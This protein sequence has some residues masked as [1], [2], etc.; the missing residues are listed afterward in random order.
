MISNCSPEPTRIVEEIFNNATYIC[1]IGMRLLTLWN[2][3]YTS[4]REEQSS[5]TS[6]WFSRDIFY[7]FF[8]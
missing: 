1:N 6:D 4:E 5:E 2:I 3:F 8:R 7:P